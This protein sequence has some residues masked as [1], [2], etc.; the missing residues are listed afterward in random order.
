MYG[1]LC[2]KL[3]CKIQYFQP[4]IIIILWIYGASTSKKHT[5]LPPFLESD[6]MQLLHPVSVS[7]IRRQHLQDV[8]VCRA[9]SRVPSSV[10]TTAGK[11]VTGQGF[12]EESSAD[13]GATMPR[14]PCPTWAPA[15]MT[16]WNRQLSCTHQSQVML[17][18]GHV[19]PAFVVFMVSNWAGTQTAVPYWQLPP[20]WLFF[21]LPQPDLSGPQTAVLQPHSSMFHTGTAIFGRR[22]LHFW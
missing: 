17:Q 1:N 20:L 16:S 5:H 6:A 9:T 14:T 13:G 19:T 12:E 11:W 8:T 18:E 15:Q 10:G 22:D 7:A 2:K 3:T 4:T 21:H